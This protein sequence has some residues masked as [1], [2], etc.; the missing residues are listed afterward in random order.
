L[1]GQTA[2]VLQ[3]ENGPALI[4]PY[5]EAESGMPVMVLV[6]AEDI[7]LAK[8]PTS[9]LSAQNIIPGRVERV[10]AHGPEAEAVI[11]TGQVTWIVSLVAA[12]VEQ[13]LL[14]PG[15]T[16][17]MIIKARSCHILPGSSPGMD[18]QQHLR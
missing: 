12:A 10:V 8:G 4:V 14:S 15:Q 9:V 1:P 7:I 16:V 17:E 13:L 5:L 3:L 18:Y 6:R 2:T 11:R